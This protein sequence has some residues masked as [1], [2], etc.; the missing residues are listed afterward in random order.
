MLPHIEASLLSELIELFHR[1][2]LEQSMMKPTDAHTTVIRAPKQRV[3]TTAAT[4]LNA[5]EVGTI[6]ATRDG[7]PPIDTPHLEVLVD[8]TLRLRIH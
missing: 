8:L 6:H 5:V 3:R 2:V 4:G 1:S 7:T